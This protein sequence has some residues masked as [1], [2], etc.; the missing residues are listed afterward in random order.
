LKSYGLFCQIFQQSQ[1]KGHVPLDWKSAKVAPIFKKG[2]QSS[3]V[4]YRPI[5]LSSQIGK[6]LEKQILIHLQHRLESQQLINTA[7]EQ[8]DHVP[9]TF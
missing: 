4:N 3:P 2:D 5:S 7:S 1:N 9:P 6:L 8:E